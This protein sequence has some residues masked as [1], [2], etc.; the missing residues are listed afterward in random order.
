MGTRWIAGRSHW[1]ALGAVP[2]GD[3]RRDELLAPRTTRADVMGPAPIQIGIGI[4][5][6]A[7]NDMPVS[8][9]ALLHFLSHLQPFRP[10]AGHPIA[11]SENS[12]NCRIIFFVDPIDSDHW[13]GLIF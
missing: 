1:S 9:E 4:D 6:H 5:A 11:I 2:L 8:L 13:K 7:H 12:Q 10:G 3:G